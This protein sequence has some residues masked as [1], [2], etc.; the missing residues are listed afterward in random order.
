MSNAPLYVYGIMAAPGSL[1]AGDGIAGAKLSIIEAE[2]LAALVSEGMT[3]PVPRLRRHLLV[4]T[5]VLEQAMANTTV[6]P[7]RFGTVAP[8]KAALTGC[9]HRHRSEFFA[10]IADIAGKIEVGVKATWH[11][12][13]IYKDL[14]EQDADLRKMR[15]RLQTQSAN[16]TYYDRIELGRRVEA[17]L[18]ERGAACAA[19][20]TNTLA[21]LAVR[22]ADLPP[23]EEGMIL[24]KAFLLQ[25]NQEPL[26]D[27]AIER[28]A[29]SFGESLKLR[30]VGPVPPFNFV[31]LYAN[32]LEPVA[33]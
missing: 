9:M 29:L 8:R 24:N 6:L 33:S 19:S 2:G 16:E 15:D 3:F 1:P 25:R 7:L 14:I 17:A 18:A 32:W 20:I 10:E 4:H 12:S 13:G 21:A 11:Q 5:K 28:I 31:S 22:Q 27:A 30:Y 23:Q 26:F